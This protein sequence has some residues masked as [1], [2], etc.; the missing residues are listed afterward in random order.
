MTLAEAG[1][2][3][4]EPEAPK[5]RR[6]LPS[7]P[8]AWLFVATPL[9]W[10]T[11]LIDM[12]VVPIAVVMA[13]YLRRTGGVRVPRGFAVWMVFL[14]FMLGSVIEV[15]KF[16]SYFTFTYRAGIYLASTVVFV[17]VYNSWRW[18]SD[19]RVLGYLVAYFVTMVAGGFLGAVK[20]I[21]AIRTPMYYVLAKVA[22]F[23]VSNDLVK[24]MVVRPFSQY[25]PT[26]YFKIPP[27]PTAPFIYTNNWGNAYS[28]LLPIVL[29]FFL[30]SRKG[31]WQRRLSGLLLPV[32]AVPAMLTLNRG[33]FIGLGIV[34]L[35][36]GLRLAARGY[37][38][39]V[40]LAG[41]VA[42][43]I[44]LVLWNALNVSAG[45]E[46][47]VQAST[48]TRASLYSQ[49]LHTI[50]ASPFFGYGVTI[51][52]TSGSIYDPKVGTQGQFWMVLISHGIVAIVCFVGFFLLTVAL[53]FRR[54]DFAGMVY[55]AVILSGTIET[56]YYGLVPYG[57]P[58][59]MVIAALAFRPS[60]A[61]IRAAESAQALGARTVVDT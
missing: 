35:Y 12:I 16:N 32:S 56:I 10:V 60:P 34:A 23:M 38:G 29:V 20:P 22:P 50:S 18:I 13:Y 43:V 15:T 14:F 33:M 11:G 45:L 52:S 58:L 41:A 39:R 3:T 21:G 49:S 61:R 9:W 6:P 27:R 5:A 40:V 19:R 55:N 37:L 47:R 8:L 54:R 44:G 25:D 26:N 24:V 28:L 48:D 4:T 31:T 7:W 59:M 17:Y 36:V 46:T 51:Q 1:P 2:A 53:T 57:L 30:E 42:G